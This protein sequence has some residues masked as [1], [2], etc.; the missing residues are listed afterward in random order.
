[1]INHIS[2]SRLFLGALF[3][4]SSPCSAQWQPDIR[5]TNNP[6]ESRLAQNNARAVAAYG[7]LVFV[8]WR[9]NSSG[10]AGIYSKRSTDGGI[11]WEKDRQLTNNPGFSVNPSV[12]LSG[13]VVHIVWEDNRNEN[14]EIYYKRSLDKGVNWGPDRRLTNDS[15]VSRNPS[16]AATGLNLHV[17]WQDNRDGVA[18][19]DNEADNYEVYYKRSLDSGRSWSRRPVPSTMTQGD[20]RLTENISFSYLPAVAAV[21]SVVHVLWSDARENN[22]E[23]YYKRSPDGGLHWEPDRRLTNTSTPSTLPS[24]SVQGS[25]VHVVWQ[26]SLSFNREI[27]YKHSMD[28]GIT[29]GEDTRLTNHPSISSAPSIATLDRGVHV[30]WSDYRDGNQEIYYKR[31]RD[32][33]LTWGPDTRLTN[34]N[35]FSTNPSVAVNGKAVH[36]VWMDYR[37]GNNEIY[38][39]RDPTG[40]TTAVR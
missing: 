23:I 7:N 32:D 24:V 18:A 26:E 38:Y 21:G 5:L 40:N 4:L 6:T 20:K 27:Y 25:G 31:S 22:F 39:K 10:S 33:G 1:M 35:S 12:S 19:N 11:T 2:I 29:W 16:L 13:S 37:D 9:E 30:V 8:V 17:V 36:V 15:A 14:N 34:S 28:A 3:V